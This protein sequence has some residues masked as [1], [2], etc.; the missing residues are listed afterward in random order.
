MSF[1]EPIHYCRTDTP[2]WKIR[3]W[4][5]ANKLLSYLEPEKRHFAA[6]TLPDNSYAQ[7]FGSKTALTVEVR[8]QHADGS[9]THWVFGKGPLI[10]QRI[11]VGPAS[12]SVTVDRSQVLTMRDARLIIREF[13]EARTLCARYD[14]QDVSERFATGGV[15]PDGRANRCPAPQ[16]G[17]FVKTMDLDL[18]TVSAPSGTGRSPMR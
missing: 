18:Q 10:G 6:F 4:E 11:T 17:A 5:T 8:E 2:G 13:L 3:D 14:R 7:C 16:F 15:E 9:F 1:P 12:G